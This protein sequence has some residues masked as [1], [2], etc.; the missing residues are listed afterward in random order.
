MYSSSN[1][2]LFIKNCVLIKIW[3]IILNAMVYMFSDVLFLD[4]LKAESVSY[5]QMKFSK[6]RKEVEEK[7]HDL[8]KTKS[9]A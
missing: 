5:K 7:I 3:P 9:V 4:Y 6:Q 1:Y 8:I 2:F